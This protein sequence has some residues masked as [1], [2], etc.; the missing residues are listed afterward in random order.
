MLD[1]TEVLEKYIDNYVKS[2]LIFH[3]D[4]KNREGHIKII[5]MEGYNAGLDLLKK[6]K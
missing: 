2:Y 5:F 4:M 6:L 3:P 1:L